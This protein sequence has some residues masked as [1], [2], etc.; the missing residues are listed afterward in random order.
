MKSALHSSRI[1][2]IPSKSGKSSKSG[3]GNMLSLEVLDCEVVPESDW[4]SPECLM[5]RSSS[6]SGKFIPNSSLGEGNSGGGESGGGGR[7]KLISFSLSLADSS[8]ADMVSGGGGGGKDC[9]VSKE[10]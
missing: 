7:P 3:A 5:F 10:S 4:V 1:V 8:P 6:S 9:S 2:S